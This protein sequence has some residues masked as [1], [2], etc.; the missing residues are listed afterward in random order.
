MSETPSC[1]AFSSGGEPASN[2]R[3][4]GAIGSSRAPDGAGLV[5]IGT[6]H[7]V[8]V[9]NDPLR[10]VRRMRK[11]VFHS[12]RMIDQGLIEDQARYKALFVT[13]TYADDWDWRPDQISRYLTI[14]REWARRR[15]FSLRYVWVLEL[16]KRGR[17]H[18]HVVFWVPRSLTMPKADKRGWWRCGFTKTERARNPVGYLVKY[19]SKGASADS[20]IPFGARLWGAGGLTCSQL[21]E[22]SVHMAPMWVRQLVPLSEG[23]R[24]KDGWWFNSTTGWGYRSPWDVRLRGDGRFELFFRGWTHDSVLIPV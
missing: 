19:A 14:C 16:T 15:G 22:R 8:I 18:Y 9:E 2:P 3:S 7:T 6:S 12:S 4:H 21:R 5:S 1:F 13:L 11:G 24:R 20:D 17:P 10:R 23:V